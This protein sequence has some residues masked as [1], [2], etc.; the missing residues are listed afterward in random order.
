M[1][2]AQAR[3]LTTVTDF[4]TSWG[5]LASFMKRK[6]LPLRRRTTVCQTTPGN[7]IPKLVSFV[8]HI[9]RLLM[10]HKYSQDSIFAMDEMACWLDMPSDTTVHLT[11][12][13]SVPVKTA[14]HD[15]DHYTVILS[16]RAHGTKCKPDVVFKGKGTRL[17]KNLQHIQ[18][19]VLSSVSVQ[20]GG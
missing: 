16:G 20:M 3:E 10:Q 11:V 4:K 12:V 1:I 17:I 15:K 13:R 7:C 14:G 6:G 9:L 19:Q 2:Q 5:W 18:Y 8:V